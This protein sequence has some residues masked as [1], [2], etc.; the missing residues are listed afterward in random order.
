MLKRILSLI[1]LVTLGT[2]A[3]A[4]MEDAELEHDGIDD[5]FFV[6]GKGDVPNTIHENTPEARAILRV[7]NTFTRHQFTSEMGMYWTS[8]EE[9]TKYRMGADGILRT[10]DDRVVFTL[11]EL[12]SIPYVGAT[13]LRKLR[14]YVQK[15]DLVVYDQ[16]IFSDQIPEQVS[17]SQM[18]LVRGEIS[19]NQTITMKLKGSVGDRL[20]LMLRKTS[21][22]KW[23]PDL[24]I[25][26]PETGVDIVSTNPWGTSDARIPELNDDL[27]RG[28]ELTDPQEYEVVL[29]NANR[30]AGHFEFSLE[31]VGG[32][33][34]ADEKVV[35]SME[36]LTSLHED[37]LRQNIVALH[38][39]SHLRISYYD[40]RMEMFSSL[41]NVEG[42]VECVYTGTIVETD[43]IPSNLEMNA[44]HTWPQSLGALDGAAKSDL[45]H[46]FPVTSQ[47]NS[48]RNVHPFCEV[49]TVVRQVDDAKLGDDIKGKRCFEPRDWHKGQAARAMFYFATVYQQRISDDEEA[50]LRKWHR[51]YPV[52]VDERVRAEKIQVFQGSSQPFVK[53][54]ELV[55]H[56]SDF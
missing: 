2:T 20:L 29:R 39:K 27:G 28:W 30:I 31:C 47:I 55:D 41:D 3:C 40:A 42:L 23:N 24:T 8:A 21:E 48:I 16:L 1:L 44:E 14:A 53:F 43:T 15:N 37:E 7:V 35:L 54:P 50:V 9:I 19:G 36:K 25:R 6:A 13:A 32:P 49:H 18:T 52:S 51:E 5:S 11:A 26:D 45:H 17:T 4:E 46:I 56:I 38:E 22:A 34:F 10:E 12:D 33:C